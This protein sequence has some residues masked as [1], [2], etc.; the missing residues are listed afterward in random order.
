MSP[1]SDDATAT[2]ARTGPAALLRVWLVTVL[3]LVAAAL[4]FV[5]L[6]LWVLPPPSDSPT[7]AP[8]AGDWFWAGV[9]AVFALLILYSLLFMIVRLGGQWRIAG[10]S[11][12]IG[13]PLIELVAAPML[14]DDALPLLG[15]IRDPDHWPDVG[16][17]MNSDGVRCNL[18]ADQIT[19]ESCN[20]LFL[21]DSFTEGRYVLAAQAFPALL[22]ERLSAAFPSEDIV[23]ANLGWTSSSPLLSLRRLEH[24]G[25]KYQP[26]VVVLAI[27]MSDFGGDINSACLLERRGIFWFYDKAPLTL[28]MLRNLMPKVYEYLAAM[29]LGDVPTRLYFPA[30]APL[31]E[32]RPLLEPLAE[33]VAAIAA[34]CEARNVRFLVY[35]LPRSFPIQRQG[36]PEELGGE[37]IRGA[38]PLRPRALPLL[39]GAGGARRLS[40]LPTAPGVP[41]DRRVS[42]LPR[43]GPTLGS[44][45]PRRVRR[46]DVSDAARGRARGP[47]VERDPAQLRRMATAPP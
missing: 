47:E 45:R 16:E 25:W 11:V 31:D 41:G 30:L 4:A 23:V 7:A 6:E 17:G 10:L 26:D 28:Q 21:G 44:G 35:V 20:V 12:V 32:T 1:S 3:L 27:D 24:I 15:V 33:N 37:P 14:P 29:T 9:L 38:R 5:A 2:P 13:W 19:E 22:G 42:D 43:G 40:D 34:A 46:C 39:R 18:E 8:G 36:V